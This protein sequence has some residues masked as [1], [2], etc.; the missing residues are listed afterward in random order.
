MIRCGVLVWLEIKIYKECLNSFIMTNLW[1]MKWIV[2]ISSDKIAL[3]GAEDPIFLERNGVDVELWKTLVERDRR[4]NLSECLVLNW[5]GGF[6]NLRVGTLALNLLKTLKKDQLSFFTFS[7]LELYHKF[8]QREWIGRYIAVYI[9]QRLNVWLW[10]LQ[11]NVLITTVKKPELS[12]LQEKYDG[13]FVDQTY[14]SEYFDQGIPQLQYTFDENGCK[15]FWGAERFLSWEELISHPV[16][17][18]EPNYM[19]EPNIS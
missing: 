15:F 2:D 11:E 7:K 9:G 19:I 6:T 5:P 18:L 13:L 14:E 10:D 4:V 8:Y 3:Y 12:L 1:I 17:K 16:E